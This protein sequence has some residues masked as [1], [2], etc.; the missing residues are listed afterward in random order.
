MIIKL[1]TMET[2]LVPRK[3]RLPRILLHRAPV[4]ASLYNHLP[5]MF[6]FCTKKFVC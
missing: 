2:W 4:A 5:S 3:L 6:I 1:V